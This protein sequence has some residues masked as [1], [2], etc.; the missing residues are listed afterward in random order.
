[1]ITYSIKK[2]HIIRTFESLWMSWW[3]LKSGAHYFCSFRVSGDHGKVFLCLDLQELGRLFL[4]RQWLLN[5][6]PLS[7]MYLLQLWLLNGVVRV[8]AWCGVC[9][10]LQ[11]HMHQAQYLLTKL[12]LYAMQGGE[13]FLLFKT[14]ILCSRLSN[15][16]MFPRSE[17]SLNSLFILLVHIRG[18]CSLHSYLDWLLRLYWDLIEFAFTSSGHLGSMNRLE[19]WNLNF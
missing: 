1:M 2:S 18:F 5:V 16:F 7:L 15:L 10:I 6:G 17:I 9:L 4:L 19:G 3:I 11:E 12:I 8:N 13:A 14:S